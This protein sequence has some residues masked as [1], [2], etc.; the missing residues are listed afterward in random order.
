[1]QRNVEI[2]EPTYDQEPLTLAQDRDSFSVPLSTRL[3][4]TN[5]KLHNCIQSQRPVVEHS[6]R[7]SA[8]LAKANQSG[9]SSPVGNRSHLQARGSNGS[10]RQV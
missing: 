10:C 5:H 3:T 6:V 7:E 1:M 2:H 9:T 8:M 4:Q